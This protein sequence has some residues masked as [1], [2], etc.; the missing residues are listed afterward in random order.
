[1]H[2]PKRRPAKG[3]CPYLNNKFELPNS[4]IA[5]R[6]I[7]KCDTCAAV[8]AGLP[9][10]LGELY[11]LDRIIWHLLPRPVQ[12][13]MLIF[14]PVSRT[15]CPWCRQVEDSLHRKLPS[16]SLVDRG[17]MLI[18]RVRAA[19]ASNPC[20]DDPRHR[21]QAGEKGFAS[22]GPVPGRWKGAPQCNGCTCRAVLAWC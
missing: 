4:L 2:R 7:S 16:V 9:L 15:G 18:T 3:R 10:A 13:S 11:G 14:R 19:R 22:M 1:M 20:P 21:G 8:P 6:H 12:Q 17:L 5:A